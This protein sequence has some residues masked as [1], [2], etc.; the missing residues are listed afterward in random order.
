MHPIIYKIKLIKNQLI[1]Q[2]ASSSSIKVYIKE[3][4]QDHVL[5]AIFNH[6]KYKNLTLYG[7]TCLRKVYDLNRMSEDLDFETNL[8]ININQ[9]GEC[10]ASYFKQ[11][12]F[13][14]FN[15]STQSGSK[16]SRLTFKFPILYDLGL[17]PMKSE[18]L[19]IKVEINDKQDNNYPTLITPYSQGEFSIL[20][21]HYDL[22]TLMA[23]KINACLD[24]VYKKG[25]TGIDIKG[26]DF[27]D[28]IWYMNKKI[29]PNENQLKKN[30]LDIKKAFSKLDK[31]IVKIKSKDL[32]IDLEPMFV[33]NIFIQD[34]CNNFH[35]FYQR[36]REHYN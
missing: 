6:K 36:Y 26:R 33:N 25:N 35:Q 10:L 5:K 29:I 34:W 13:E 3:H 22:P 15:Y 4:L 14:N 2:G 11:L 16:I 12:K 27:Y 1:N 7:G 19:H 32:L 20:I 23:G 24:R 18:K 21:K 8:S 30:S 9:T 28:L 31:K 17:S